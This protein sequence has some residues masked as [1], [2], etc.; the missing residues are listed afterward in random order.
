MCLLFSCSINLTPGFFF[1][2]FSFFPFYLLYS[3]SSSWERGAQRSLHSARVYIYTKGCAR[4]YLCPRERDGKRAQVLRGL[5][6]A[7]PSDGQTQLRW[8]T[9]LFNFEERASLMEIGPK[10]ILHQDRR[11]YIGAPF[12]MRS[13]NRMLFTQLPSFGE[14]SLDWLNWFV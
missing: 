4:I 12:R 5:V 9:R 14:C 2:L 11:S 8:F 13:E 7:A 10:P 3:S 6:E 1:F